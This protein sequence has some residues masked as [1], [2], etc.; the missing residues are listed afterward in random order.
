MRSRSF[1]LPVA[2]AAA[3]M[4]IG[5]ALLPVAF[6]AIDHD[7]GVTWADRLFDMAGLSR[8]PAREKT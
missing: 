1:V 5:L 3:V 8:Q 6:L 4:T 2:A 7:R